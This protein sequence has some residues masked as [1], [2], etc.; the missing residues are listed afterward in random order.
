MILGCSAPN[1]PHTSGTALEQLGVRSH[2]DRTASAFSMKR[3]ALHFLVASCVLSHATATCGCGPETPIIVIGAGF[4][5]LA[6]A[7]ELVKL[8]CTN[9]TIIEA[10]DR[11]GGRAH[12]YTFPGTNVSVDMGP[13]WA[14]N[15]KIHPLRAIAEE[16][17][18]DR[19]PTNWDNHSY[20]NGS[21]GGRVI[22]DALFAAWEDE[23]DDLYTKARR[24]GGRRP[25][26]KTLKRAV[27][28][29]T[30]NS[31][32]LEYLTDSSITE[33]IQWW[34]YTSAYGIETRDSS[35]NWFDSSRWLRSAE[36][37]RLDPCY[38][39]SIID[40]GYGALAAIMAEGFDDVRLSSPVTEVAVDYA[41]VTVTTQG[42]AQARAAFAVLAAPLPVVRDS[43]AFD[44]P[45]PE[46]VT[47]ALTNRQMCVRCAID[48][49]CARGCFACL[50]SSESAC[51]S[52]EDSS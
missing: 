15:Y 16:N 1:Y 13:M 37:P 26:D 46:S 42:G 9:I 11:V 41:G 22:D 36:C 38:E 34:S 8:N 32:N 7:T 5:G 21:D 25:N 40:R 2:T 29:A 27:E 48:V 39:Y 6:A 4:A 10:R 17:G 52:R 33:V 19:F 28:W 30:E 12:T 50:I 35:V 3:A 20:V 49:S 23:F 31:P 47:A 45:L 44:P 18:F 24:W 14:Y 51:E 43:I